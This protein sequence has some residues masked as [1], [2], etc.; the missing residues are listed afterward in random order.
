MTRIHCSLKRRRLAWKN[1]S[2]ALFEP[3]VRRRL[4]TIL[5]SSRF[6]SIDPVRFHV[7]AANVLVRV[8]DQAVSTCRRLGKRDL[9]MKRML[10]VVLLVTAVSV[11]VKMTVKRTG[12]EEG[13][14]LD[15]N[16]SPRTVSP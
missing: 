3:S 11:L 6:R 14:P 8:F 5:L 10:A 7:R 2:R 15:S 13:T 12:H 16:D 4:G 9:Q 1:S